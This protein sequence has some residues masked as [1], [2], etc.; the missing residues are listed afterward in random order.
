MALAT[1]SKPLARLAWRA[2]AASLAAL[3]LTHGAAAHAAA[4]ARNCTLTNTVPGP[5]K[6]QN[7]GSTIT[8]TAD[9]PLGSVLAK[10]GLALRGEYQG[11]IGG[12][13]IVRI[14]GAWTSGNGGQLGSYETIP[15]NIAGIGLRWSYRTDNGEPTLPYDPSVGGVLNSKPAERTSGGAFDTLTLQLY[16]ELILTGP[17]SGGTVV[18][19]PGA[20]AAFYIDATRNG[21]VTGSV[22]YQ[23]GSF[24]KLLDIGVP[25]ANTC[26]LQ[27]AN[28]IVPMGQYSPADFPALNQPSTRTPHKFSLLLSKCA[29][30][31]QPKIQFS[32]ANQP[33]NNTQLLSIDANTEGGVS[34]A[35]GLG[36]QLSRSEGG[37]GITFGSETGAFDM[38]SPV[39]GMVSMSLYANY[40]R[41]GNVTAG[42]ANAKAIFMITYP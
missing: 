33:S 40:V 29:A 6:N 25:V 8:I 18:N 39:D 24:G 32:D 16:Q 2:C 22:C 9:K 21:S 7:D 31:A 42:H 19:V 14:R 35:K 13:D 37:A 1:G 17:T 3:L 26:E 36:L 5:W 12:P 30:Q 15:T 23:Q 11:Q 34:A 38:G 4:A 27:T 10:R 28:V 41:T 20:D